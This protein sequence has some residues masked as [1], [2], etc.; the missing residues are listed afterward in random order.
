MQQ[1]RKEAS[2]SLDLGGGW[3]VS[4]EGGARQGDGALL[5]S[6]SLG[7]AIPAA[8][9]LLASLAGYKSANTM[10]DAEAEKD[11]QERIRQ[12]LNRLGKTNLE[13]LKAVRK[14][15]AVNI[16]PGMIGTMFNPFQGVK[17][18]G[19]QV[20]VPKW[21]KPSMQSKHTDTD[22]LLFKTLA[23]AST[24]GTLSFGLKYLLNAMERK[25]EEQQGRKKIETNVRA[26]MPILSPD[27]SLTDVERERSEEM[28]GLDENVLNK[29]AGSI[30]QDWKDKLL[31]GMPAKD[32]SREGSWLDTLPAA[33][34]L[35]ALT[36]FTGGAYFGKQ[37]ADDRDENR[38]RLKAAEKAAKR[39]ALQS[40]PPA[41]I[42][43]I[44]PR[45]KKSLD[46]HITG[47]GPRVD[48]DKLKAAALED[49]EIDPTD[50]LSR[51]IATV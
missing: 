11:R 24:Y 31:A 23:L 47:S 21:F 4:G 40:R 50:T 19:G 22:M 34:V 6:K 14:E 30:L 10:T 39:M 51:N 44:D 45:I 29:N 43:S 3:R 49:Q 35:A 9:V 18:F 12:N 16:P 15:A 33:A 37:W 36:A 32:K 17:G 7:M 8:A 28:R 25:K 42:G 27:P 38:Q 5:D 41:I 26:A 13:I 46:K 1:H 2:A 20:V 48:P